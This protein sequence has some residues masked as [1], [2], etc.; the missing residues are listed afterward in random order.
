MKATGLNNHLVRKRTL[1]HLV[2]LA[3]KKVIRDMIIIYS[4]KRIS[5]SKKG[6]ISWIAFNKKKVVQ[7][8][9]E[10]HSNR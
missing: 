7:Q 2:K 6:E 3:N 8:V 4:E 5:F 9:H 10:L 1:N